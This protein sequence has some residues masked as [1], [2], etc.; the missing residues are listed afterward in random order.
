[1]KPLLIPALA[2]SALMLS[3]CATDG[4]YRGTTR[5]A[6][7]GGAVGAAGGAIIAGDGNRTEGAI[8]GG[9]LGAAAG[10][11]YGC[12]RDRVCPWDDRNPNHS[13]LYTDSRTGE[14]YFIDTTTGD[15]YWEDGRF[16]SPG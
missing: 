4:R 11:L 6:A 3:A 9:A 14:R 5:D 13:R 7:I 16:R 8:V 1:M 12:S 10:A 2:G 15:T